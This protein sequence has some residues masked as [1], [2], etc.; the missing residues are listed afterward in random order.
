MGTRNLTAVYL[1][2]KLKVAQ[3]CQ[4]D[5][6]PSGQGQTA[7]EFLRTVDLEKF[8]ADV[9]KCSWVTGNPW[10]EFDPN[11]SGWVT[12][13]NSAKFKE[14]YP[15]L[16]R[17]TGAKV[18]AMLPCKLQNEIE[19]VKDGLFCEWAYVIDLDAGTFE[20]YQGFQTEACV[21]RFAAMDDPSEEYRPVS[22][23][24]SYPLTNLPETLEL[25]KENA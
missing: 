2:G 15:E 21:G 5:G 9:R 17:D 23:V 25:E 12:M 24:A 6:Y 14:K 10:D 19:F 16:H 18:L 11:G 22:L 8:K 20:V 7:L 4:W 13:E 3:Y 1:D